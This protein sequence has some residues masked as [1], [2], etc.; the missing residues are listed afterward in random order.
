MKYII[1][2]IFFTFFCFSQ[3][4]YNWVYDSTLDLQTFQKKIQDNTD[5]YLEYL[6]EK[7]TWKDLD[8]LCKIEFKFT[9]KRFDCYQWSI[10]HPFWIGI[11]TNRGAFEVEYIDPCWEIPANKSWKGYKVN[12]M[13]YFF[14][15][16]IY[17]ILFN[18]DNFLEINKDNFFIVEVWHTA[19][20]K[21]SSSDYNSYFCKCRYLW[22]EQL[23]RNI[24]VLDFYKI[25]GF[26]KS[27]FE[28]SL[29]IVQE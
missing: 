13:Y 22:N 1:L 20:D 15:S 24:K 5:A 4:Y 14:R 12:G 27:K 29:I 7:Q 2:F 23:K 11:H 26:N 6:N 21:Q 16:Y 9:G 18:D 8:E 17:P 10:Y 28:L 19:A 3:N 25:L